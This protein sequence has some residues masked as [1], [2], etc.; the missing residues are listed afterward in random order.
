MIGSQSSN[1][2]LPDIRGRSAKLGS[3][4]RM[5][6]WELCIIKPFCLTRFLA[7][8]G[9]SACFSACHSSRF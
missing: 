2:R 1:G 4:F 8:V 5:S 9:R 7:M 6:A 3:S